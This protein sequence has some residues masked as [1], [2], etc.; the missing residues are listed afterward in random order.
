[1]SAVALD[2]YH[3]LGLGKSDFLFSHLYKKLFCAMFSHANCFEGFGPSRT[4]LSQTRLPAFWMASLA[5]M[6]LAHDLST[7]CLRPAI[8]RRFTRRLHSLRVALGGYSCIGLTSGCNQP[9]ILVRNEAEAPHCC[10]IRL[11]PTIPEQISKAL[12]TVGT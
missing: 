3:N 8:S 7:I 9:V 10:V 6:S 5:E 4:S 12:G 2:L 11:R 1:M